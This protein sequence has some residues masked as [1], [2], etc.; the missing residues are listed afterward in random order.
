MAKAQRLPSLERLHEL[1]SYDPV[2]GEVVWKVKRRRVNAGDRIPPRSYTYRQV[3]VDGG[4]Y[5]LHR[6]AYALYHG[7]DPY[8]Y[9]VDHINR[10]RTDNR[11]VN[12][13]IATHSLNNTNRNHTPATQRLLDYNQRKRIPVKITYP[14]GRIVVT[15]SISEAAI[16]LNRGNSQ[17]TRKLKGDGML[18]QPATRKPTGITVSYA[19]KM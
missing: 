18:L 2:T 1:L 11:I 13:R 5:Q 12:L 9:L 10:D 7:V 6:L 17:I 8:P 14:D 16:L 19:D 15:E 4:L 3:G